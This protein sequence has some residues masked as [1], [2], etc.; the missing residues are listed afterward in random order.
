MGYIRV[1]TYYPLIHP[2]PRVSCRA[3]IPKTLVTLLKPTSWPSNGKALRNFAPWKN[4][5]KTDDDDVR[6]KIWRTQQKTN[7]SRRR[8]DKGNEMGKID[9]G[10]LCLLFSWRIHLGSFGKIS[11]E[12]YMF[13]ALN[14]GKSGV[15]TNS[16]SFFC[17]QNLEK[18]KRNCGRF[19]FQV[20]PVWHIYGC[21]QQQLTPEHGSAM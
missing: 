15:F 1:T 19:P 13:R 9:V 12:C 17:R 4:D 18:E 21:C 7:G 6:E 10:G 20:N 5:P 16:N 2:L 11:L 14:V 8:L 3:W